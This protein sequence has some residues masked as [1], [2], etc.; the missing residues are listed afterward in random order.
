MRKPH[1]R[2]PSTVALAMRRKHY[3]GDPSRGK[4]EEREDPPAAINDV[5]I[6][7]KGYACTPIL[8]VES[9]IIH[10]RET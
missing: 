4:G 1:H 6:I 8:R 5:S 3:G 9:Y 10:G 2:F 7:H